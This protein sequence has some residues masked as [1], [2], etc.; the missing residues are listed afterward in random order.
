MYRKDYSILN[1]S[2]RHIYNSVTMQQVFH[3]AV[4]WAGWLVTLAVSLCLAPP[5]LHLACLWCLALF[6]SGLLV[7]VGWTVVV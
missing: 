4:P 5:G 2:F 3:W 1:K 6:Q 7:F